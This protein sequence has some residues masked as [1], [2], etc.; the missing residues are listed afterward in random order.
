MEYAEALEHLESLINYEVT[1]RA[2]RVKGLKLD[3]MRDLVTAMGNPQTA[4]PVVHITGTNGKG[5][6]VRMIEALV[7]T[8]GLR[9]GAYS[10][11]HLE[12]PTERIRIG[13][14]PIPDEDFGE[15]IGDVVRV[16]EAHGF[17]SLTWFETVTAAALNH[18]A[19]EAV[20]LAV[21]EVGMLGR[22]D[23]T[24]VVDA[25]VSVVTNVGLDHTDGVGEL[26]RE[27]AAEKAGITRKS[28]PLVLGEPDPDLREIFVAEGADP[29]RVRD[30]DFGV[31]SDQLAVGGR[32]LELRTTRA[33]HENLFLRLHGAHQADNAVL[34]LAAT[35]E[36][37]DV[38]LPADVV[39][40]A[41]DTVEVPGRLEVARRAPLVLLDSA[42]NVPGAA[43]LAR[44]LAHD[45]GEGG[46]RFLV[47]GMQDGRDPVALCGALEV[48]D[49]ELVVTCTAP[50]ARGIR[51]ADVA[52]AVVA[53]GG[54]AESATDVVEAFDRA[55]A[56]A[57]EDDVIVVVGSATVVGEA[58]TVLLAD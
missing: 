47:L 1:P 7:S 52:A 50:T 13:G 24:N 29:V 37:F 3:R 31:V 38:A 26:R 42:H 20:E 51:S 6:T 14:T 54:V 32:L 43:A 36:F 48:A 11:P 41:F 49:A 5:S 10:S 39:M 58:R 56:L 17:E 21:V 28:A 2:G 53:A 30:T 33:L 46:R 12:S 27:I 40:D 35:E 22:F 55:A 45:F 18:L 57:G 25:E 34:A 16:A 44:A 23:A 19:N 4:Y 15:A 9:T 8:L